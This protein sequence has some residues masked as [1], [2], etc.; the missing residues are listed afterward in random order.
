MTD[1]NKINEQELE[2]VTGGKSGISGS[3]KWVTV[4]G[5]KNYLALRNAPAYDDKNEIGKLQNGT[6][7]QIRADITSGAYV[8][9]Y[10]SNLNKEG[11]VNANYVK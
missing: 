10:A 9:A 5:T 4:T 8:W 2:Q 6:K 11:W 3:W 1:M 7:I